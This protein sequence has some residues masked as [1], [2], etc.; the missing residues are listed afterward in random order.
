MRE[1]P[2]LGALTAAQ[3]LLRFSHAGRIHSEAAFAMLLS[4]APVPAS[5]G[6]HRLAPAGTGRHR[7]TRF[8]DRQLNRALQIM[9]VR[10]IRGHTSTRAYVQRRRAEGSLSGGQRLGYAG[11]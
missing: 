2:G 1:Q 3:V 11:I 7:L 9:A 10:R 5:S 8:G 6:R 4:T